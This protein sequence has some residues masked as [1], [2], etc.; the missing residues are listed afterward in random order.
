VTLLAP[1]ITVD[2]DPR[3][4]NLISFSSSEIASF[5][6][7]R[8]S[9]EGEVV[10]LTRTVSPDNGMGFRDFTVA[11]GKQYTYSGFAV[12]DDGQRSPP[13]ISQ[14]AT[15]SLSFVQ[16][17][18]VERS[19]VRNCALSGS[20]EFNDFDMVVVYNLE[21]QKTTQSRE[22]NIFGR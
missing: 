10:T 13:S 6:L 11:S 19:S 9:P 7:D 1:T 17:H 22:A 8:R 21:G 18:R 2:E 4:F 16:I 12:D 14:T 3:G 5:S 20:D 15:Q